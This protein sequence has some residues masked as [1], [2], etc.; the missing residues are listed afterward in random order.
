MMFKQELIKKIVSETNLAPS[1][2]NTQP[3]RW[4]F[5]ENTSILLSAGCTRFLPAGGPINR[6]AA[7]SCGAALEGTIMA[8]AE[9]G[10]KAT[11]IDDLWAANDCVTIKGHRLAAK[12]NIKGDAVSFPLNKAITKRFTWRAKFLPCENTMTQALNKW[13]RSKSDVTLAISKSDIDFLS[14]QNDKSS[15][16]FM[17]DK[18]FRN[19]LVEWMRLST[20]HQNYTCD[21][22]NLDALQM[23][24]IEGFGA[25][26]VLG[27]GLFN[28][29]DSM[30]LAKPLIGEEAQTKSSSAI[31]LFHR[32][33]D[34]SPIETG[35][36]FYRFWLEMTDLGFSAWPMAVVADNEESANECAER[37]SIPQEHR[38]VN[39]LRVGKAGGQRPKTARLDFADLIK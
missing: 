39:V 30:R 13:S 11:N 3:A 34:E 21:G 17:R 15:L 9:V 24:A 8:L 23:S 22:L 14:Q 29:L 32:P 38:L 37:F 1:T 33:K 27:T 36:A 28:A 25:K 19:E 18:A 2:H 31:T 20:S 10:I 7:L 6:D 35:R 12:I 5:L 16:H 26:I 4:S